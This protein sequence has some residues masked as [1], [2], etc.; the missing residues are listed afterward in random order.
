MAIFLP[1]GKRGYV[2]KGTTVLNAARQLNIDLDSVCG[3]RGICSKCQISPSFGFFPKFGI[4]SK[5]SSLSV[6]NEVEQ[7]YKDKRG[8]KADRRLGCQ[9]KILD[10]II[11]D[12]PEDSQLHKQVVRKSASHQKIK[13]SPTT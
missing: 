1:S 13:M 5:E 8:L 10:N 7:R 11:I 4:D 9:V 12:V 3:G 2:K 6:M